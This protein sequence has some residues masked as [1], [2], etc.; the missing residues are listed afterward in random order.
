MMEL[1][2]LMV[3]RIDGHQSN[4]QQLQTG[5]VFA[6][7]FSV[8]LGVRMSYFS[9]FLGVRTCSGSGLEVMELEGLVVPRID[10]HQS[11][12]QQLQTGLVFASNFSVFSVFA[13]LNF[14]CFLGIRM[15]SG[16]G[17]EMMELEGLMVPRIDGHPARDPVHYCLPGPP[18]ALTHA[19]YS[20]ILPRDA[21]GDPV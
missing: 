15:C 6:S 2:G 16:S 21:G 4:L 13:C 19:L 1:E 3:P 10:G 18:D 12:L 14:S 20:W 7:N 17:L 5:L 8:F 11:N 9:C